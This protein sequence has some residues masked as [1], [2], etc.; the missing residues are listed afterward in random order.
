[1]HFWCY[2]PD[3]YAGG[4]DD[5]SCR[6]GRASSFP[7]RPVPCGGI[8]EPSTRA[9][10]WRRQTWGGVGVEEVIPVADTPVL[11]SCGVAVTIL[12]VYWHRTTH[13]QNYTEKGEKE[14][15]RVSLLFL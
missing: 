14:S 3:L 6:S 13:Q 5:V 4:D 12:V 15:L 7:L 10:R 1:M 8:F 2:S 11:C 9:G